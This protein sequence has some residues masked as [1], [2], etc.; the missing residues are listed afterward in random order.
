MRNQVE[1]LVFK[2][3][4]AWRQKM[5]FRW[6]KEWDYNSDMFH[7]MVSFWK[8]KNVINR[9]IKEDETVL[10]DQREIICEIV[11]FFENLYKEGNQLLDV[12]E[13]ELRVRLRNQLEEIIFKE[14][15]AWRQKMKIRWI[16]E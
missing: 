7:C 16:K 8:S 15:V 14:M 11:A 4:V 1:E 3:V 13:R 2:E 9:I 10:K 6:I 12:G 5:K